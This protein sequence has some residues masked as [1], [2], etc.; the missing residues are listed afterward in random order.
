LAK[1]RFSSSWRK[2][3]GVC[4]RIRRSRD[5]VPCTLL[6]FT[7]FTVSTGTIPTIAAPVCAA[8]WIACSITAG[9][10]NG[11]TASC[12]ATSSTP[13]SNVASA[14]ST[15]CWRLSPP[16]TSRPGF[17]GRSAA[18]SDSTQAKSSL[19]RAMTISLTTA[20]ARN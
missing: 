13:G 7:C 16:S 15:D 4:A 9:S 3:C 20:Q 2:T 1:A 6:R 8:S 11:R 17:A 18:S 19:R 12:T 10:M 14:F 5:S